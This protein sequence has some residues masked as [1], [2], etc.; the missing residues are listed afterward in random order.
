M[1][2]VLILDMHI[3]FSCKLFLFPELGK[4]AVIT[5]ATH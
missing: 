3:S 5:F 2:W 4:L 1:V